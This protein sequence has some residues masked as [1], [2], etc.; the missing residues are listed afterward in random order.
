MSVKEDL[1]DTRPYWKVL[2]S[3]VF[4]LTATV[5][6]IYVGIKAIFYFMPFVIGWIL[7]VIAG[8]LVTFLE[9]KLKVMKRLGSAI[10]II[11]VLALCIGLIYLIISQIWEEIS[12]LIRNFPSMYHDLERGLSQ[13][14]AQGNTLFERFP[15]QIQ[16]SW[17][18]LMNNLDDTASSLIGRIG[19][20]TIEV[21]GN[22]AK[23]IPS[24]LIG[25]IVAF[26]SA[27]FFIADKENLGEWVKKV[28]PKSITSRL[29]LV[30]ENLKY[31]MGGYFKAQFKIMGVVFAILL[32]GFTLMQIRF[33][34]LLAIVI[35]FLDFL[36][37][38]GTGTALIPWAIYKFLVGDYKMVAALV[39]LYGVT[40]LVRQLIQP[41][42]VGDSMGLNPLYTLFLLYLGYRVGSVLGMIFAVPIGLILLNLYQA[43]AFDYILNDVKILAEGIL[44][45]R[46]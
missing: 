24:V 27:Y 40:Q 39:I 38:F 46:E 22:V 44:S 9:K 29:L 19:E 34:I 36:P 16:N 45:L 10:T 28:V 4:S 18:T 41:K 2:V 1:G 37:F 6:F 33:S 8:P 15:E 13:I 25:T 26:V 5:L 35:A 17:A 42:L 20:P 3:L 14:G 43:G 32:V 7:S 30:G 23:R 12:V 21:A 31:A 11:L